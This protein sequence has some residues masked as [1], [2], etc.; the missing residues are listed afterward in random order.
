MNSPLIISD[1][2]ISSRFSRAIAKADFEYRDLKA[3]CRECVPGPDTSFKRCT[4][5]WDCHTRT[6]LDELAA[7][8]EWLKVEAERDLFN[9]N[10]K[11][12]Y[13]LN[14]GAL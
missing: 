11:I 5:G 2:F 8:V 13:D 4:L 6:K 10:R 12:T 3:T 7:K 1:P 14:L 9:R